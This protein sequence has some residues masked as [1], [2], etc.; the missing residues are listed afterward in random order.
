MAQLTNYPVKKGLKAAQ[1]SFH[2]F[3]FLPSGISMKDELYPLAKSTCFVP[4]Y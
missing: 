2:T 1:T 3:G 4:I